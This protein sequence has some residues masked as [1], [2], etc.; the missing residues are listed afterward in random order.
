MA[1][2]EQLTVELESE[3]V[4][5]D[6]PLVQRDPVSGWRMMNRLSFSSIAH[7]ENGGILTPNILPNCSALNMSEPS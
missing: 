6:D 5:P 2:S 4:F 7:L 1:M 3:I